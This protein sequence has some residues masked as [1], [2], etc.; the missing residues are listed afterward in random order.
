MLLSKSFLTTGD[1]VAD[2]GDIFVIIVI[3]S[4]D[5]KYK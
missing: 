5:Y 1:D 4:K 2:D 3:L